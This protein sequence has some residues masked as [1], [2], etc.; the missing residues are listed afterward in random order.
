MGEGPAPGTHPA[1]PQHG[2]DGWTRGAEGDQRRPD[3]PG[4]SRRRVVQ[5]AARRGP[6][7]QLPARS[8]LLHHQ[9]GHFPGAGENDESTLQVL[10]RDRPA[11]AGVVAAM[12]SV[13]ATMSTLGVG[14]G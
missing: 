2:E 8:E 14:P 7:A 12:N 4:Y 13:G 5:L 1:G 6:G 11:A 10:A 3:A 9:G